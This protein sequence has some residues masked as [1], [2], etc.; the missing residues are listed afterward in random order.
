VW[1]KQPEENRPRHLFLEIIELL[2]NVACV[3]H[4]AELIRAENSRPTQH[5]ALEIEFMTSD[6]LV[7]YGYPS[8]PHAGIPEGSTIFPRYEIGELDT[9]NELIAAVDKDVWN[10]G[11]YHPSW[12]LGVNWPKIV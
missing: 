12:E 6:P 1:Q 11:G 5:F 8:S 10:L 2:W 9:L 4:A 7:I 3:V